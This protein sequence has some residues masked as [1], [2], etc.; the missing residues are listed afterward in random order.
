M[1]MQALSLQSLQLINTIN[2]AGQ[3]WLLLAFPG[4]TVEDA[5]RMFRMEAPVEAGGEPE[6]ARDAWQLRIA[7]VLR[8]LGLQC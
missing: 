7:L 3:A 8:I 1:A 4:E 2:I 6:Q 5:Q